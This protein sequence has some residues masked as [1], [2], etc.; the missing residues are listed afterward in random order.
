MEKFL[1]S[2]TIVTI[3]MIAIMI[4]FTIKNASLFYLIFEIENPYLRLVASGLFA[5]AASL[6]MLAVSVNADL[7][8]KKEESNLDFSFPEAFAIGSLILILIVLKVF[9]PVVHHWTWYFKRFFLACFLALLEYV[10]SKMFVRKYEQESE[11]I[12]IEITL[13][14]YKVKFQK[15]QN[16]LLETKEELSRTKEELKKVQFPC[17]HCGKKLTSLGNRKKHEAKC[18]MNPKNI[19]KK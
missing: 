15:V 5:F 6:T 10:F 14:E 16:E 13:R 2:I 4:A 7:F 8:Q 1:N 3:A 11:N 17:K 18:E 12:N 9:E 19:N